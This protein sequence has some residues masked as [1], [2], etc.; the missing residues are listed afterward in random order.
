MSY[1]A[2]EVQGCVVHLGCVV[3]VVQGRVVQTC[4]VRVVQ[5]AVSSKAVSSI[6]AVSSVSSSLPCRPRLC[7]PS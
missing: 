7:R 4:V 3:R 2:G 1:P 5:S 6:L